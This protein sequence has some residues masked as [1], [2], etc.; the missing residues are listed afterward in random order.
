[1]KKILNFILFFL[2]VALAVT[3]I[4]DYLHNNIKHVHEYKNNVIENAESKRTI[5]KELYCITK[6]AVEFKIEIIHNINLNNPYQMYTDI[7]KYFTDIE[8]KDLKDGLIRLYQHLINIYKD[9]AYNVHSI[10]LYKPDNKTYIKF[11][12]I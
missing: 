10:H 2:V 6:D 5:S 7:Q 11:K 1:M 8:Y 4:G 9:D 3:M 12:Y